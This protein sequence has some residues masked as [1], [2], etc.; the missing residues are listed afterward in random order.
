[1]GLGHCQQNHRR[2]EE[3]LRSTEGL[4][5]LDPLPGRENPG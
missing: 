1:V 4:D 5:A 3:Q 2:Q